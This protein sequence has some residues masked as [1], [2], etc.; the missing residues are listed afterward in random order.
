M[1]I[2]TL[3][4]KPIEGTVGANALKWGTVGIDIDKS[5][6]ATDENTSRRAGNINAATLYN[7][8]WKKSGEMSNNSPLGRFPANLILSHLPECTSDA[9]AH[10]CPIRDLDDQGAEDN[11]A[12]YFKHLK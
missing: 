7:H 8:G 3:V 4:R 12:R 10:D 5:R 9:C 11:V 1:L 6:I 2:I